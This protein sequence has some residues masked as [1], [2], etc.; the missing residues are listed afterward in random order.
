MEHNEELV[1]KKVLVLTE[2]RTEEKG[3]L[4]GRMATQAPDIDG[5]VI[6]TQGD[7]SPGQMVDVRITKAYPYD[8]E[9]GIV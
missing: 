8:L 3:M 7:A 9:G 4:K 2:G 5:H 1:G 6:I